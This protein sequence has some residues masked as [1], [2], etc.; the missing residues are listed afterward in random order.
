MWHLPASLEPSAVMPYYW[1]IKWKPLTIAEIQQNYRNGFQGSDA[2]SSDERIAAAQ[3]FPMYL[4][5]HG[6]GPK[7]EEWKYGLMW[8]QYFNDAPS[9]YF[10]PQIPNEGE[11]YRWWQKAK[12]YAWEKLL[13]QSLASG[14]VDANRLYVF[15]I[16][17]G[18]YGSQRLASYYADYWAGVGPMAGGE[19][20]KNAPVENC[21]NLA[22]S[23]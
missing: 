19:P 3:P 7:E 9:V 13:R 21:A 14:H 12:L 15:G 22:F 2:E 6:S 16:S 1:G 5:L 8:A 4:Y 10:I 20:L 23:F 17:E 11:Y 18:G